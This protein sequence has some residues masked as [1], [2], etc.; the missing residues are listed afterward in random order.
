MTDRRRWCL[1]LLTRTTPAL[2]LARRHHARAQQSCRPGT[3]ALRVAYGG[4]AERGLTTAARAQTC[5]LG[6]GPRSTRQKRLC[7]GVMSFSTEQTGAPRPIVSVAFRELGENGVLR[8]G[9]D[10]RP[11]P[12]IVVTCDIRAGR[13]AETR[14]QLAD[15]LAH[16]LQGHRDPDTPSRADD[17]S[18]ASDRRRAARSGRSGHHRAVTVGARPDPA[19]TSTLWLAN[20]F[21]H[22]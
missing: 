9:P 15:A 1:T 5:V 16:L 22:G 13:P 20:G 18:N 10:G 8:P 17:S 11:A 4:D 3:L 19:R 12:A 21:S 7:C 14:L 2:Y 6:G